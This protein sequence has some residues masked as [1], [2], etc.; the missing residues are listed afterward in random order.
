MEVSFVVRVDR[1]EGNFKGSK[2]NVSLSDNS[3]NK[4]YSSVAPLYTLKRQNT[5]WLNESNSIN[6]LVI[7]YENSKNQLYE[8]NIIN[9]NGQQHYKIYHYSWYK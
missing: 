7:N 4:L 3:K 2:E 9:I 1:F 5:I 8:L 6:K